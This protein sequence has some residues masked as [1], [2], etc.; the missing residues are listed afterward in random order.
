MSVPSRHLLKG[1]VARWDEAL[2]PHQFNSY[3]AEANRSIYPTLHDGEA[4]PNTP[5][6]YCIF[7]QD[8]SEIVARMSG[9][10]TNTKR[11]ILNVPIEFRVHAQANG[12]KS[13][14]TVAGDLAGFVMH[15]F[16]DDENE[17][18]P[19]TLDVGAHL[20]TQYINDYP[21]RTGDEEH[22][23]TIKY[24]FLVDMPVSITSVVKV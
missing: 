22:Q 21:V 7:D 2:M 11:R 3:W 13:S 9:S 15:A 5:F 24:N 14:K 8:P 16:G 23:W 10:T 20:L 17:N 4:R 12:S 18:H 6:P 19:L 1:V